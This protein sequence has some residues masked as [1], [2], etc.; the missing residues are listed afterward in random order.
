MI[1]QENLEQIASTRSEKDI[2]ELSRAILG[3]EDNDQNIFHFIQKFVKEK[4]L[5]L[6]STKFKTIICANFE[7]RVS[8]GEFKDLGEEGIAAARKILYDGTLA[9]RYNGAEIKNERLYRVIL[10]RIFDPNAFKEESKSFPGISEILKQIKTATDYESAL[11]NTE[12]YV[13][14]GSFSELIKG[15]ATRLYENKAWMKIFAPMAITLVAITLLVQPLFGNI[16]KDFPQ[17]KKK[18]GAE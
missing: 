4:K 8:R 1:K 6:A 7:Q 13:T 10:E 12:K 11:T 3:G 14:T 9:T 5:D 18:G 2:P 15:Y 16:S 17:D